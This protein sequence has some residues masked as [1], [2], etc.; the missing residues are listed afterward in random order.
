MAIPARIYEPLAEGSTVQMVERII[1]RI[2]KDAS[3]E[4][5]APRPGTTSTVH[6]V[7][8]QFPPHACVR[9]MQL[10]N[11]AL[12]WGLGWTFRVRRRTGR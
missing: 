10:S 12:K 4:K 2:P 8:A 3:S 5:L 9:W 11:S 7:W 6:R 1:N